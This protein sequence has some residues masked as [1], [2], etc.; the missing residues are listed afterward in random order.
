MRYDPPFHKTNGLIPSILLVVALAL[1]PFVFDGSY[2]RHLLI[3]AMV[4]AI[5]AAS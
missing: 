3:P 4:F 2:M 5:V 1:V